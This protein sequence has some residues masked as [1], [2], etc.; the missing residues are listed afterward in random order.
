M[1][2]QSDKCYF[3]SIPMTWLTNASEEDIERI[4]R[5]VV[6]RGLDSIPLPAPFRG[7]V[8]PCLV[9]TYRRD[10]R[11]NIQVCFNDKSQKHHIIVHVLSYARHYKEIP[12]CNG[13]Q[14]ITEVSHLCHR[15]QCCEPSHL[16]IESS[17]QNHSRKNCVGFV[18]SSR[19][20]EWISVCDHQPRC[21]TVKVRHED[22]K[23]N[24]TNR[25]DL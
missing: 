25:I 8:K 9:S 18:W 12:G 23:C 10:T 5:R 21:L 3:Y 17:K 19:Y 6:S 4:W 1:H 11:G 20:A 14:P 7:T 2:L 13:R 15:H 22:L 16:V 24:Q